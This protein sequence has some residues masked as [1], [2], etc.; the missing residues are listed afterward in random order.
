[1][2]GTLRTLEDWI[3]LTP[4]QKIT[5]GANAVDCFHRRYDMQAN[6]SGIIEI[7]SEAIASPE[8]VPASIA[9]AKASAL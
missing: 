8:S 1:V 7:F 9:K 6:A 3:A 5:M 2:A 4:E